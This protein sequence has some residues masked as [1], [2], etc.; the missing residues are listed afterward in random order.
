MTTK[1]PVHILHLVRTGDFYVKNVHEDVIL[2]RGGPYQL[3]NPSFD[4]VLRVLAGLDNKS[5]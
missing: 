5:K 2:E 3:V 1:K 4:D